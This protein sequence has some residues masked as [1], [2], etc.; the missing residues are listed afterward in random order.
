MADWRRNP[1]PRSGPAW[2]ERRAKGENGKKR[3]KPRVEQNRPA[4]RS[5]VD[6]QCHVCDLDGVSLGETAGGAGQD[7]GPGPGLLRDR[8]DRFCQCLSWG[9]R[10]GTWNGAQR[11]VV[12]EGE[13]R[14][15]ESVPGVSPGEESRSGDGGGSREPGVARWVPTRQRHLPFALFCCLFFFFCFF[16][17]R[18]R[19][20][21][22]ESQS[23]VSPWEAEAEEGPSRDDQTRQ[24]PPP[25]SQNQASNH[26]AFEGGGG[27]SPQ[28]PQTGCRCPV[29]PCKLENRQAPAQPNPRHQKPWAED[30]GRKTS[31]S[32]SPSLY[33]K[34]RQP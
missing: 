11:F 21:S 31:P 29:V 10:K 17:T 13:S 30:M 16:P 7:E 26:G 3:K 6:R 1:N 5:A 9:G 18:W 19:A 22:V 20:T 23:V 33:L 15:T 28:R 8:P 34:C 12:C 25:L 2:M 24:G 32:I 27:A 4:G 14:P